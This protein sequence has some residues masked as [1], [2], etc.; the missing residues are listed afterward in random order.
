MGSKRPIW[1][2]TH[3]VGYAI[4]RLAHLKVQ[5]GGGVDE[6]ISQ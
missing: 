6:R 1:A 5:R 3:T 4:R 2:I